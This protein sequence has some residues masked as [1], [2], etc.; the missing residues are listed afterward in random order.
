MTFA[1]FV[2]FAAAYAL[3][4]ASPGPGV[5]AL[6]AR[7][8]ARGMQGVWA[9][10]L[11]MVMGDLAWLAVAAAGLAVVAQHFA[12]LLLAIRLAGAAYLLYIAW[13]L[14]TAPAGDV[15]ISSNAAPEPPLRLFLSAL[16]LTLGNP[17]VIVFFMA[18]LPAIVDL[19]KLTVTDFALIASLCATILSAVMSAYVFAAGRARKMFKSSQ[20]MRRLNRSAGLVMAG[21]AVAIAVK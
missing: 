12:P 4:V 8:L 19:P 15:A 20:A 2:L 7:V 21:V 1:G 3:A 14:F 18:L 9:F 5:A 17:K 16:S 13:K 11:G 10:I 6:V